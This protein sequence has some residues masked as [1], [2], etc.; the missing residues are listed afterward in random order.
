MSSDGMA[1]SGH[2]DRDLK[3]VVVGSALIASAIV[4]EPLWGPK[5][6]EF[7]R[8]VREQLAPTPQAGAASTT[9]AQAKPPPTLYSIPVGSRDNVY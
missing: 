6:K 1:R 7:I 3:I 4:T 5:A 2:D 8:W 9:Q